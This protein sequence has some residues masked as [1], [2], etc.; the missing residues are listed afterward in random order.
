MGG[1]KGARRQVGK[2]VLEDASSALRGESSMRDF[3][4]IDHSS[5]SA[6]QAR[7]R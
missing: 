4:K 5:S 1:K 3:E 2:E 7:K 6:N